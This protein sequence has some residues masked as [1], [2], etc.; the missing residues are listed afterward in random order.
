[1]SLVNE[2]LEDVSLRNIA[3]SLDK[4]A[5]KSIELGKVTPLPNGQVVFP[6]PMQRIW[7]V[8]LPD[9]TS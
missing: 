6:G 1:M 3:G 4:S 8:S 7:T 9:S 2:P 5:L